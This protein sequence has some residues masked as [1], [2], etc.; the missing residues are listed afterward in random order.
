MTAVTAPRSI[1]RSTIRARPPGF[2]AD[3]VSVAGRAVRGIP[4]EPARAHPRAHD[5]AVLLRRERGRPAGLQRGGDPEL[6]LQGL[7][8]AGG[9]HLRRHRD[10]PRRHARDGHPGRL[11]RPVA[12]HPGAAAR[13]AAR[14][15]DR[16]LRP[17]VR[18][19]R[20]R[21]W[22]SGSRSGCGSRPGSSAW[23][24]SSSWRASGGSCSPAS[25]MPSRSRPA[26]P[27]RLPRA[28]SSSSRSRS[29]RRPRC[30]ERPSPAGSTRSPAT[31][32]SPTCSTASGR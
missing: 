12:A 15:D 19:L 30:R 25:P 22:V 27:A 13:L 3:L 9:D 32:P 10:L 6:R 7:P 29:S 20:A 1:P 5:P 31:T 14:P 21:S 28:S 18:P 4:R 8:A 11:L 26:A 16:R 24:P 17:G 2:V 23:S